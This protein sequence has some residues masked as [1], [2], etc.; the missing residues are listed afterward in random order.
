LAETQRKDDEMPLSLLAQLLVPTNGVSPQTVT[1][2]AIVQRATTEKRYDL[3][4]QRCEGLETQSGVAES[5]APAGVIRLYWDRHPAQG[6]NADLAKA[7]ITVLELPQYGNLVKTNEADSLMGPVYLYKANSGYQGLDKIVYAIQVGGKNIKVEQILHVVPIYTG[8][9]ETFCAGKPSYI[10]RISAVDFES[11]WSLT[12]QAQSALPELLSAASGVS[13]SFSD[14]PAGAV[15]NTVGEGSNAQITLDTAAAGH[16][17]YIDATPLDN[18][19]DYPPT[20]NPNLWQAKAGS[21]ADGKMNMLSV[22][23]GHAL[24]LAA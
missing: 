9:S 3:V 17:W 21:T 5:I 6:G 8:E 20:S 15:G 23:H 1:P 2:P 14:L 24:G 16:G 11:N 19:D 12:W 4:L 22:L 18:T 10:K 7:I 13:Y